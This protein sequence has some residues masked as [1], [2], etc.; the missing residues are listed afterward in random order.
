MLTDGYSW[1][2]ICDININMKSRSGK[3]APWNIKI[4]RN[5]PSIYPSI[6]LHFQPTTT[7]V[8]SMHTFPHAFPHA[9]WS[10]PPYSYC[11]TCVTYI[12]ANPAIWSD[13]LI[14]G[15]MIMWC[16]WYMGYVWHNEKISCNPCNHSVLGY[17]NHVIFRRI[18]CVLFTSGFWDGDG[19]GDGRGGGGWWCWDVDMLILMLRRWG[20][21]GLGWVWWYWYSRIEFLSLAGQKRDTL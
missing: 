1:M 19:D 17:F 10:Y 9:S 2:S 21:W 18:R 13:L 16:V 15:M 8:I 6:H 4:Y 3:A 12:R 5:H 7:S 11:I 20:G 14:Y